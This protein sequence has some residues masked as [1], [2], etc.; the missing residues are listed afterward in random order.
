MA[1][2]LIWLLTDQTI[3]SIDFAEAMRTQWATGNLNKYNGIFSVPT[4]YP[5]GRNAFA[6]AELYNGL[7]TLVYNDVTAAEDKGIE[8]RVTKDA[9]NKNNN[10]FKYFVAAAVATNYNPAWYYKTDKE[11][12]VIVEKRHIRTANDSLSLYMVEC[13]D[14]YYY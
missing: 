4:Y 1:R 5:W 7:K 3:S 14:S 9:T 6:N 12:K 11:G 2:N 8:Q 13:R 10:Q